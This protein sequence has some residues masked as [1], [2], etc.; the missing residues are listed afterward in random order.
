MPVPVY[1]LAWHINHSDYSQNSQTQYAAQADN[2]TSI[3]QSQFEDDSLLQR[4]QVIDMKE[5]ENEVIQDKEK[6]AH[7]Y[8][9]QKR[10]RRSIKEEIEAIDLGLGLHVDVFV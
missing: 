3:T 4:E 1:S 9:L 8:F 10:N 2:F 6:G 5:S 7:S